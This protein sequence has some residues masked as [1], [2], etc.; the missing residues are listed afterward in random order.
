MIFKTALLACVAAPGTVPQQGIKLNGPLVSGGGT[1]GDVSDY[2]RSPDGTRIVY[3]ADQEAD[4]VFELYSVPATGASS[5]V[6]LNGPLPTNG[7]AGGF[8]ITPDGTRV[9]FHVDQELNDVFE[10]YSV[11]IDGSSAPVKLSGPMSAGGDVDQLTWLIAPDSSRVVYRADQDTDEVFEVYA[12]PV[13]GSASAVKL[14]GPMVAGGDVQQFGVQIGSTSSRVVYRADQLADERFEVFSRPIDGSGTAVRLNGTLAAG[15]DVQAAFIDADGSHVIYRADQSVDELF[16]LFSRPTD[17][18]GS[19]VRLNDALPPNGDVFQ[20][21]ALGAPGDRVVYRA[22][23]S[24]DGVIELYSVPSDGSASPVKLSGTMV[25]GGDVSTV[26]ITADGTR[27]LYRADQES[28]E[29]IE[30]YSAP[31]DGSAAAVKLSG[32]MTAGGDVDFDLEI[33]SDSGRVVYRADQDVNDVVELYSAPVDGSVAAVK[34]NPALV[35]GGDVQLL[36]T[37]I[38]PDSTRVAYAADQETDERLEL[39]AVPIDGSAAAVKLSGALV[40]GGAVRLPF[41]GPLDT[42]VVFLADR[43]ADEVV[44]LYTVPIDGSQQPLRLNGPLAPGPIT[45]DVLEFAFAPGGGTIVY[46]ADQET[47]N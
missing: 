37:G 36:A 28:D 26:V 42:L 34:L 5:A 19:P 29:V 45:G 40:P 35:P 12:A 21:P 23:Q 24:A 11:P 10:L 15:G 31:I 46:R 16:E 39:Y 20:D 43:D 32:A 9:V 1:S 3:R 33:A 4:Q 38:S 27:A 8:E 17:G 7:D 13:D 47:E 18:S 25:L 44:E 14:S 2:R 41:H 30:L 22:D 6:K